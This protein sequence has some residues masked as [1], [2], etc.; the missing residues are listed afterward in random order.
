[1]TDGAVAFRPGDPCVLVI[2][3]A[4]G[5][6]TKRKLIPALYNLARN[7]L[8]AREFAVVGFA[9]EELSHDEFRRQMAAGARQFCADLDPALWG[10]IEQRLYYTGGDFTEAAPYTRLRQLLEKVDAECGT[11]ASYLFYLATPPSVF[12]PIGNQLGAAGLTREP[13]H[14][15]WRRIIVEKPFGRDLESARELNRELRSVF[16]EDQIYRIDHY[17]GKETVQNVLVFR[18][19]NGIFE[20]IWNR[21]YIDH[22]QVLVAETVGVEGR[23]GY[24]EEAGLLRDMIQNHLLQLLA[25]VAMEPPISFAADAVRNEKVKVLDAVHPMAPEDIIQRTVRGQYDKG[26]IDGKPVPA[27]RSEPSVSPKSATETYAALKLFVDNWRWADV[28]FYLRSGKRL[29]RRESKIVIQFRRAPLLLFRNAPGGELEPNRL[30]LHIQPDERI[31][32]SFQ[33]KMPGATVRLATV[34]MDFRYAD[35]GP[36]TLTTGYETLIYDCMVGDS[37]LFYRSDMVEAA[38]TIATPILDVWQALPPRDFPNYAAGSWGPA[39]ADELIGRD[40]RRWV[41]PGP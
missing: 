22:V 6:L 3:G 1:M 34:D 14:P 35:L 9:R 21:R 40:G 32:V 26:A 41:N 4:T 19:A 20:P 33:V 2:F 39:A 15:G 10:P 12:A 29:G 36:T 37:T 27:Y 13:E 24:Y 31:R 30:V 16:R 38:W 11:G 7:G 17:L 25:L 18:F 5:D 28:P 8:L 23:G